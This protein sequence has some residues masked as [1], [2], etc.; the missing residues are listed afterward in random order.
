[1][2]GLS[3]LQDTLTVNDDN[4]E[5]FCVVWLDSTID[6]AA[7][8]NT[9]AKLR[10]FL[11][12]FKGFKH[13]PDGQDYIEK[14]SKDDRVILIVSGRFGREIVP[15]IHSLRQISSI[16]VFCMDKEANKQWSSE[17]PKVGETKTLLSNL[18]NWLMFVD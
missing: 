13:L 9:S 17:Y 4:L 6:E 2:D 18:S 5:T 15:K 14:R 16:Y 12:S 7:N 1:M 11:H 8:R 3:S 10:S